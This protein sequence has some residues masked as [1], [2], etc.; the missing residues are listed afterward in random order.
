MAI[1][2]EESYIDAATE[3]AVESLAEV[4]EARLKKKLEKAVQVSLE[5]AE[6][7]RNFAELRQILMD[8]VSVK[9]WNDFKQAAEVKM[10]SIDR[11]I[12]QHSIDVVEKITQ[13]GIGIQTQGQLH[14]Q[15][16]AQMEAHL[17]GLLETHLQTQLEAHA[18]KTDSKLKASLVR[19]TELIQQVNE[20]Q[21]AVGQRVEKVGEQQA[22][23]SQDMHAT[24]SEFGKQMEQGELRWQELFQRNAKL[25]RLVYG[26]IVLNLLSITALII[27]MAR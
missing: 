5:D 15:T 22:Q 6:F 16:V 9:E 19:Q 3:Q 2:V 25:S 12:E 18:E 27:L 1:E 8:K 20:G 23:W 4:L 11:K 13:L 24:L 7:K 21:E 10:G 17:Q 14:A 26:C